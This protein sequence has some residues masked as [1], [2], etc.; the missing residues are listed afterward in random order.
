MI[1]GRY[2]GGREEFYE[3]R[4]ATFFD[5]RGD[6]LASVSVYAG[7]N[8]LTWIDSTLLQLNLTPTVDETNGYWDMEGSSGE[9]NTPRYRYLHVSRNPPSVEV[10]ESSRQYDQTEFVKLDSSYVTGTF[11]YWDENTKE[12]VIRDFVSDE[13]LRDMRNEILAAYDFQFADPETQERYEHRQNYEPR[14][15]TYADFIDSMTE[16]DRH[17]LLFLERIIGTLD[18]AP[19]L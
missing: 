3:T 6:N 1:K 18:A 16:I 5:N 13:T 9:W 8:S 7:D 17:N 15:T 12:T 4:E 10:L 14:Y 11:V 2:L 19:S